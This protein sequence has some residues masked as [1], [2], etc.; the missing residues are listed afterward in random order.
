MIKNSSPVNINNRGK[1]VP[2]TMTYM[3]MVFKKL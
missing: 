2:L 1:T 3:E